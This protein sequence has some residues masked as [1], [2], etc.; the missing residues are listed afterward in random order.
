MDELNTLDDLID[1]EP[2]Q[3][4]GSE[5]PAELRE[6]RATLAERDERH[7]AT[8]D[9]LRQALLATEPAIDPEMVTGDT[10]EEVEANFAAAL[11]TVARI[12]EALRQERATPIPT[13]APGRLAPAP[14]TAL[15]KIRAGLATK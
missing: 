2:L 1:L 15:E 12:R 10:L 14:R 6:L 9:R 8:L 4:L 11:A 5:E 7:H 13:G 3:G